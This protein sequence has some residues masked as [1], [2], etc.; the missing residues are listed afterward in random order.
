MGLAEIDHGGCEGVGFD[1][2]VDNDVAAVGGLRRRKTSWFEQEV[3]E[4]R[5]ITGG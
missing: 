5:G 2:L 4:S 3:P 1:V